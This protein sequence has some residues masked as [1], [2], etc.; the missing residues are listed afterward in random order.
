M[1]N[2]V[3]VIKLKIYFCWLKINY[4]GYFPVKCTLEI[5]YK[6]TMN[7]NETCTQIRHK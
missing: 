3:Y 5:E 2:Q 7:S 1:S 4:A 6:T